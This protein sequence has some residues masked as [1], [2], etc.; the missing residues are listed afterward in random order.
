M[1][2]QK[3]LGGSAVSSLE[4]VP[5]RNFNLQWSGYQQSSSVVPEQLTGISSSDTTQ[6][7]QPGLWWQQEQPGP[8]EMQGEVLCQASLNE[9]KISQD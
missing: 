7:K 8:A 1:S 5:C 6:E 4:A 9:V 2:T 3:K